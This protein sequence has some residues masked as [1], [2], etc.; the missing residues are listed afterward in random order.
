MPHP[1]YGHPHA[2]PGVRRARVGWLRPGIPV[3]RVRRRI[4]WG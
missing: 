4:R 2:D 1:E 3:R